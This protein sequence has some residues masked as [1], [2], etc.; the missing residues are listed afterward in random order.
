MFTRRKNS[1][2]RYDAFMEFIFS[3]GAFSM[4]FRNAIVA[5]GAITITA[6]C[7][8][9]PQPTHEVTTETPNYDATVSARIRILTDNGAGG[10][11]FRP[12]ESCYKGLF[13]RDDNKVVV[14][15]GFWS[16][17]KYSSRS[18]TIGMP[19][20]PRKWMTVDGLEFKDL[21]REYVVPAGKPLTVAIVVSNSAGNFHSSCTPP[22]TTFAPTPGQ[23]Y[24]IFMNSASG[25]CWVEVRRIDGHGMDEFTVQR[26]APKCD[27]PTK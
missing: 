12:G 14:G 16:A 7:T 11:I 8:F 2:H 9:L 24:D 5:I 27:A 10:A 20:S 3:N 23:D 26:V 21:I 1:A 15:D 4:S 25:R 6:A 13:E 17:W 22:A 19:T 18:I